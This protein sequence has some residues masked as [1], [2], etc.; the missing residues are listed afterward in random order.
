MGFRFTIGQL[1]AMNSYVFRK[2]DASSCLVTNKTWKDIIGKPNFFEELVTRIVNMMTAA[3]KE[4]LL[5]GSST[6]KHTKEAINRVLLAPLQA[7]LDMD[8]LSAIKRD[9]TIFVDALWE[10]LTITQTEWDNFYKALENATRL[11]LQIDEHKQ[12]TPQDKLSTVKEY[13]NDILIKPLSGIDV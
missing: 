12:L 4:E 8:E 5:K 13:V 10:E 11:R 2:T 7:D 6:L 9:N 1:V 3:K